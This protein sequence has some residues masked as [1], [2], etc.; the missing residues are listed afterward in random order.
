MIW[1][2]RQ[3]PAVGWDLTQSLAAQLS[4]FDS[5]SLADLNSV[6]LLDRIEVKYLLPLAWLSDVL[7]HLR[8]DYAALV[9]ADR[10]LNH[11]RT[12]YFDT[13]DLTMYRRHHMGA[14]NRYKVRSRQYVDSRITFLEV[15]HKTNKKHTVKSR[16]P[17]SEFITSMNR[18]SLEF[19]RDK[20]PYNAIEL[21]PALWN[22]Y[23][24]VTLASKSRCERVT[25][26]IGLAFAWQGKKMELPALVV[27]E[28]K[29]D[30]SSHD[31]DFI[32]LMRQ[33]GVRKTGFSK[34]CVGVS[35][36]Y[37]E[38]K[39]NRFRSAHRQI[40]RLSTED[41]MPL[42]ELLLGFIIN[43][44][45]SIVIVRFI[46]YPVRHDKN[47]VFTFVAFNTVIFL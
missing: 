1:T 29:R 9:V 40:A 33:M 11:Y 28:V 46:Y 26:D 3:P 44:C 42:T 17:T 34:Y 5:I 30:G 45:V 35:L 4:A 6:A 10:R 14:R 24:R 31:S 47:D 37:P 39:H 18:C 12:L 36:L 43:L 41:S 22:T 7:L 13:P 8:P 21:A 20:C 27:A 16:L 25:L 38:L 2:G 32:T 23:S 15:K 19:L